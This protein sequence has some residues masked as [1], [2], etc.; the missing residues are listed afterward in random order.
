MDFRG[1]HKNGSERQLN[2]VLNHTL[3][4]FFMIYDKEQTS[5]TLQLTTNEVENLNVISE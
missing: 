5:P 1:K 3:S 2:V 4:V